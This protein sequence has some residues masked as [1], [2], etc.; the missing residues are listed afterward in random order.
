MDR[1]KHPAVIWIK[2]KGS[3]AELEW[4]MHE[5]LLEWLLTWPLGCELPCCPSKDGNKICYANLHNSGS[6]HMV[7]RPVASASPENL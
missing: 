3:W 5:L 2:I 6:Q 7:P 1:C 4:K